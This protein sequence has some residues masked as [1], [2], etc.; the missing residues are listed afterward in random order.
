[1]GARPL[2]HHHTGGGLVVLPQPALR[3]HQ[4]LEAHAADPTRTTGLREQYARQLRKRYRALKTGIRTQL[5]EADFLDLTSA[6]P[7]GVQ[8]AAHQPRG[9]PETL[10]APT[11]PTPRRP[12]YT[13]PEE[14]Q[15]MAAFTEWLQE[16]SQAVVL[17]NPDDRWSDEYVRYAYGRGVLH[18]NHRLK[19]GGY[20]PPDVELRDAFTQPIHKR[21]LGIF[22]R[23]QYDRLQGVNEAMN[24]QLSRVL[25]EGM[26][27]GEGPRDIARTMTDV[28]DTV[29]ITRANT[30]ARTEVV[31]AYNEAA[32][33]RYERILGSTAKVT[34]V[35]ELVTAGD[36]RVCSECESLEGVIYTI[37]EA[38]NV[39]PVHPNCRCV[40]LPLSKTQM[41]NT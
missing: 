20:Q 21:T 39:V 17:G 40:W 19:A 25:T 13:F 6:G 12:G 41:E 37:R 22:Y 5:I 28:V 31:H 8:I 3:A 4:H 7:T 14:E 15:R 23:R 34:A 18:A 11:I 26:L 2:T 32:L 10:P 38:H 9:F 24:N 16:A 33:N 36:D 1:M 35:V 29:G 27:A 30:I